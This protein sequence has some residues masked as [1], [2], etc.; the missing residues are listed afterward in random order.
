L[1]DVWLRV[2]GEKLREWA[3]K[4]KQGKTGWGALNLTRKEFGISPK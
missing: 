1:G 2:E 3:K 4:A